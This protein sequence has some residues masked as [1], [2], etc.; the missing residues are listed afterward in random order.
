MEFFKKN[1]PECLAARNLVIKATKTEEYEI[2]KATDEW[3]KC[4]YLSSSLDSEKNIRRRR[5]L[6]K[7]SYDKIRPAL[8]DKKL[9]NEIKVSIFNTMISSVFLYNSEIWT[10]TGRRNRQSRKLI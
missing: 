4:R 5:Q 10:T 9:D 2:H 6:A 8:E 3:K 1:I 7:I